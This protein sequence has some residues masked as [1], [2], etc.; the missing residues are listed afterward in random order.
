MFGPF[1][2][3]S[4]ELEV[5][6]FDLFDDGEER[7]ELINGL[8]QYV[9]DIRH[10]LLSAAEEVA[11]CQR[12]EAGDQA[13]REELICHNLRLVMSIA[14]KYRGHDMPL[15]DLIQEGNIGLMRAVEKFDYRK[16]FK[17]STYATWWIRQAVTRALADQSRL[18]RLPV[19]IGE[20]LSRMRQ[21]RDRLVDAL[22][23][24]PTIDELAAVLD[25]T[26]KKTQ[27][28]LS[29]LKPM[30]SLDAPIISSKDGDERSLADY[31]PG[32]EVT[33]LA[34]EQQLQAEQLRVL[35][36]ELGDRERRVLELRFGLDGGGPRTLEEVGKEFGIT[37]ERARQIERDALMWLRYPGRAD[38]LLVA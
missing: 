38:R 15:E 7:A 37:R 35:L 32:P 12:M 2:A 1:L 13:A 8:A 29:A 18:V 30:V 17:F 3:P 21:V 33:E 26:P 31:I 5:D 4:P 9:R 28:L 6:P 10:E 24:E 36:A 25:L 27:A 23:R 22:Q 14:K 19:H 16:G 20:S 34:V 11:L